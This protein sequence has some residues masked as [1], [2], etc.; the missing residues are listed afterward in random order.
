MKTA[1]YKLSPEWDNQLSGI[2]NLC[3]LPHKSYI[4]GMRERHIVQFPFV[5]MISEGKLAKISGFEDFSNNNM[6]IF[7]TNF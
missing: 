1:I 7:Y 6:L 5:R 2:N 4:T 3:F